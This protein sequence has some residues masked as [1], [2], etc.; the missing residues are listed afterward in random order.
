MTEKNGLI[1]VARLS[2]NFIFNWDHLALF[3]ADPVSQ[4]TP[5]NWN[6]LFSTKITE[7]LFKDFYKIHS[8]T[9]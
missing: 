7:K 2:L 4:K 1:I 9:L 6:R 8:R 5:T 3:T